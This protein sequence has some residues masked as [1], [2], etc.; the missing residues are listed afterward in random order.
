MD[1]VLEA[2]Q[3]ASLM[4]RREI[5]KPVVSAVPLA[6]SEPRVLA[7]SPVRL[8]SEPS[9]LAIPSSRWSPP[10]HIPDSRGPIERRPRDVASREREFGI[11]RGTA[12]RI[13][14]GFHAPR[15]EPPGAGYLSRAR[16]PKVLAM[17][18][19]VGSPL[20]VSTSAGFRLPPVHSQTLHAPDPRRAALRYP[21]RALAA[22]SRKVDRPAAA[23]PQAVD[24]AR[25]AHAYPGRR[26]FV[27]EFRLKLPGVLRIA[28][29]GPRGNG[30]P[31]TRLWES[32]WTYPEDL[33]LPAVPTRQAGWDSPEFAPLLQREIRGR[34]SSRMTV[35]RL[36]PQ[37]GVFGYAPAPAAAAEFVPEAPRGGQ[38]EHFES[39]IANWVGGVEDW[40][41]DAAGV[42]TG[43]LALYMPSLEMRDYELEFFA[44]MEN[45]SVTWVFRASGEHDYYAATIARA[46]NENLEFTRYATIGG[47]RETAVSSRQCP[48]AG[49][50]FTVRLRAAGNHFGAW[51]DGKQIDTWTD[52]RLPSGGIGFVG[53]PLD[54]ARIYWVRLSPAGEPAKEHS[55]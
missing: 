28:V 42:R 49:R 20:R 51:L 18:A 16:R 34:D 38:Q 21:D 11:L 48:R 1:R 29:Q 17:A 13:V 8:A 39:G 6:D 46:A 44:R 10:V 52:S 55:E 19:K 24:F 54:R 47:T 15:I 53:A 50:T 41:V 27:A 30:T 31:V 4:R 32:R 45:H 36:T 40:L 22:G 9:A 2:N 3:V 33:L 25:R 5:P 12:P 7:A 14:P 37:E 43:A 35:V 26:N 23:R